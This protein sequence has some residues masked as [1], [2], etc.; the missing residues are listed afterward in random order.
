[1][2]DSPFRRRSGFTLVELLVVIGMIALLV[3]ILLPALNRAREVAKQTKCLSNVRQLVQA[4]VAYSNENRQFL[5]SAAAYSA[6]YDDDF[7]WWEPNRIDQIGIGGIGPYLNLSNSDTGL[8]VMRCPSDVTTYRARMAAGAYGPYPLSYVM[9]SFMV[10]TDATSRRLRGYKMTQIRD[11][12][13]KMLVFEEDDQ[14]IDDGYATVNPGNGINLLSARHDPTRQLPDNPTTGLSVNGN[15][16]GNVGFC[17][18]HAEYLDRNTMHS[19]PCY[20]PR[21]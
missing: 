4:F 2:T 10:M 5:P 7:V 16:H 8:A 18:G 3:G 6:E 14:T 9:N 15:C 13:S 21:Y 11:S 20:D 12:A 19:Q 17:D 1:V